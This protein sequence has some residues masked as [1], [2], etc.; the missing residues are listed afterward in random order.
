MFLPQPHV[1][2]SWLNARRTLLLPAAAI[3]LATIAAYANSFQGALVLDDQ[4]SITNNPTI[5]HLGRMGTV[6]SPPSGGETVSGRPFLNLSLAINY[7]LGR[8]DVW[9]YHAVNLAVHIL[10]AL[11]LLGILRRTFALVDGGWWTVDGRGPAEHGQWSAGENV[12]C[13]PSTVRPP[14]STVHPPPSTVRPPPSTVHSPPSTVRPLP[15]TLL[16][17]A[18]TLLWALHPLQTESVTYIVQR[19]ESLAGLFYLLVLY[20]L[21]RG[22]T[23]GRPKRWFVLAVLAC[24]LGMATKELLVTAPLLV[25]CYDGI[26]LSTGFRAA[27]RRRWGFYLG[28]AATWGLLAYL[29]FSTGLLG[30]NA[31]YGAAEAVPSGDYVQSQPVVILHYLRLAI[32][33]YPLCL[34]YG[35]QAIAHGLGEV[36]PA[37]MAVGLLLVATVG[38]LA[39]HKSWAMPGAWLFLILAPSS[40]VPLRNVAFEHRMYLPLAAPLTTLVLAGYL[41]TSWL[42]RHGILPRPVGNLLGSVLILLVCVAFGRLTALRNVDYG[43]Q[44]LLWQDTVAKVARNEQAHFNLGN[45]LRQQG[46][47]D[48][49]IAHYQQAL[50]IR[51]QYADPH[52]NLG[53]VLWRQGRLAEAAFHFQKFLELAPGCAEVHYNLGNVLS[54][55]GRLSEA[56]DQ[57]RKALEIRPDLAEVHN[58]LGNILGRQ[59]RLAEALLCYAK[60]LETHPD[61]AEARKNLG[62]VLLQQGKARQAIAQ[63]REVIHLQPDAVE[64]LNKTAWVLA[65]DPNVA[66]R[67]GAE[68]VEFATRAAR[69]TG[70]RDPAVLDTLA[71]AYAEAGRFTAAVQTAREAFALARSQQN[72]ALAD[73]I[74]ARI[75]LYQ[76]GVPCRDRR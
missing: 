37:A 9:G 74:A 55:Q 66:V 18:I 22:A 8:S 1:K 26:F 31:G 70:G 62:T 7:A 46:R 19:A 32:W 56:I 24:L 35:R 16:A 54:Q 50:Q 15:S 71:A 53:N 60:A 65:T 21:F 25:L 58:N 44:L 23:S 38:G 41:A 48:E 47:L 52:N 6:L 57:Y 11:V 17:L 5:R 67:N 20:G 45:A 14:P 3:V 49:A 4:P 28:L 30:K 12:H 42:G 10:A 33:P 34:D 29:V 59:G 68:G 27:L 36:L 39:R 13:P 61:F 64:T 40:L 2:P 43:S 72:S 75:K 51:P 69:L 76:A 73:K 63:W